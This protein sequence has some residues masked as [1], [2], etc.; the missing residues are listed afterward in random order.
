[1][2]EHLD[3][4]ILKN[5]MS[6]KNRKSQK[7]ARTAKSVTSRCNT[8]QDSE[9]T[10]RSTR[11]NKKYSRS[12]IGR[13]TSCCVSETGSMTSGSDD[14]SQLSDSLLKTAD[15][16]GF[17]DNRSDK[18]RSSKKKHDKN[19]LSTKSSSL[20]KSKNE[21]LSKKNVLK[22]ELPIDSLEITRE[23]FRKD[24]IG[25]VLMEK[26]SEEKVAEDSLSNE[27]ILEKSSNEK[28]ASKSP[29]KE[30]DAEAP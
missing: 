20:M 5:A 4:A 3:K 17:M 13:K 16:F 15:E 23:K 22:E 25:P 1:M 11:L 6:V 10:Q 18:K 26:P 28:A 30:R 29:S 2:K 19:S 9:S 12:S 7:S 24:W 27:H 8:T 14:W 21:K